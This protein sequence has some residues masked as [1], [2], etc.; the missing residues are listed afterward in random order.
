MTF[1][2]LGNARLQMGLENTEFSP[3]CFSLAS[4]KSLKKGVGLPD[5]QQHRAVMQAA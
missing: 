4:L 1:S 5:Q 2:G 3:V